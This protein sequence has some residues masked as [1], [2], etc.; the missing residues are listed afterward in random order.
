MANEP[1]TMTQ[2]ETPSALSLSLPVEAIKGELVPY[3]EPSVETPV[4][5][6][7]VEAM[8][9]NFVNA[10]L[11]TDMDDA[12]ARSGHR[13]NVDGMGIEIQRQSALRS[14][15]LQEPIKKLASRGEDGGPVAN[16]LVELKVKMEDLNPNAYDFNVSGFA[17][18][19]SFIPGVGNRL[20]RYFLR[21]E[22]SQG[23]I[24]EIIRSLEEGR[25]TLKRDNITLDGDQQIMRD[26]THQLD[27]Q[28]QLGQAID[29]KLSAA[30]DGLSS[31]DPKAMFIADELLFP[32][33]Q[34]IQD[35]QQQLAVN[36]QGVLATEIVIRNNRELMRGVDRALNVTVSALSVAVT[37]ALA[38][39][40]QKLVLDRINALNKTTS[41]LISGTA[42]K[43]RTQGAAI[44]N[45]A[46]S[47]MLDME[48]LKS[49]FK[50]INQAMEEITRYRQDALP[51]MA[52][53]ILELDKLTAAGEQAIQ[54]LEQG[55]QGADNI[56]NL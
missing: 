31:D 16:A 36:Q 18:A 40:N 29:A 25:E 12:A 8:A 15:M 50:D 33:R 55:R 53:Q 42:K 24:D 39:A 4:Y 56:T 43:L 30:I 46:S 51:K 32:L 2:V 20:Q 44:H 3:Q 48:A 14:R 1:K 13:G 38:L 17:K 41:D 5:D 26:L 34:R 37:V 47:S 28:V 21:Y 27:R 54:K 9:D 19:L 6:P 23:I 10:I 7:E 11:G 22:S 45:Q 52:T 49:S 35:L